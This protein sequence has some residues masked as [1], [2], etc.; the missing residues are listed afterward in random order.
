MTGSTVGFVDPKVTL[1]GAPTFDE[2]DQFNPQYIKLGDIDGSGTSDIFYFGNHQLKI[3]LNQLNQSGNSL[4]E[5]TEAEL[6]RGGKWGRVN[7]LDLLA[8]VRPAP[9][10]KC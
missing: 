6:P 10:P 8:I 7:V 2:P 4:R 9:Q 5:L 3:W 1:E